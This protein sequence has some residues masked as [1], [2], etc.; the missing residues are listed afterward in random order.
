MGNR[1][2][3]ILPSIESGTLV[4]VSKVVLKYVPP[5]S[6]RTRLDG[7]LCGAT[8]SSFRSFVRMWISFSRVIVAS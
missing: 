3:N 4:R 1:P 8:P 2:E 6:R 7:S 5:T